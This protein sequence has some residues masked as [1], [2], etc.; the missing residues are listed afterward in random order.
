MG[1]VLGGQLVRVRL[2][3]AGIRF[4]TELYFEDEVF[5]APILVFTFNRLPN[6]LAHI[7]EPVGDLA[8][9]EASFLGQLD[10]A[11]L[12][13]IRIVRVQDEPLL[14]DR[15]LPSIEV[16]LLTDGDRS[17]FL[18]GAGDGIIFVDEVILIVLVLA[19]LLLAK[20]ISF[21]LHVPRILLDRT[22]LALTK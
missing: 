4:K 8:L 18:L 3:T 2:L 20:V 15:S 17:I 13:Q 11:L 22:L 1:V 5:H 21:L 7:G 6:S 19:G 16:L 10:P 9:F 12:L 14:E